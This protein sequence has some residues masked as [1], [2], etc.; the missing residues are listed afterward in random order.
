MQLG[1]V[2]VEVYVLQT[3]NEAKLLV[4]NQMYSLHHL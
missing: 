3:G 2:L 1:S 4:S